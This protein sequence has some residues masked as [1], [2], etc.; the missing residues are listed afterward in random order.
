MRKAP[1]IKYEAVLKKRLKAEVN[2]FIQ[3]LH[4]ENISVQM[5]GQNEV[6]EIKQRSAQE[7]DTPTTRS[8]F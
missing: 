5:E 7:L 3:T 8:G 4:K 6:A 2:S 1:V